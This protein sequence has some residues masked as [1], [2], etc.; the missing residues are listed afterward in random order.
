MTKEEP[1][2]V[3]SVLRTKATRQLELELNYELESDTKELST[4]ELKA[5]GLLKKSKNE[6]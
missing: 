2:Q 3:K 1:K 5:R 6:D 4:A